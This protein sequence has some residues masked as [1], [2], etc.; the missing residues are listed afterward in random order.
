MTASQVEAARPASAAE[1]GVARTVHDPFVPR[2]VVGE[3]TTTD[4]RGDDAHQH[5]PA[6]RGRRPRVDS[7]AHVGASSALP[8]R[9]RVGR[10]G[11][12]SGSRIPRDAGQWHR[13]GGLSWADE[14]TL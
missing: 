10:G 4:I 12:L 9:R 7:I 3:A 13:G 14:A 8:A 5:V 2:L 11:T 1:A 6:P